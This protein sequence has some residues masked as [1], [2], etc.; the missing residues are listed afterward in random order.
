[1]QTAGGELEIEIPQVRE[2]AG[3]ATEPGQE[4]LRPQQRGCR[5]EVV[6]AKRER[7]GLCAGRDM[8]I[9]R[10]RT[11]RAFMCQRRPASY[12]C[13][14]PELCEKIPEVR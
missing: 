5:G 6:N 7:R 1:V 12:E 11:E 9:F 8:S 4:R 13:A 2:A 14:S 3:D 10:S